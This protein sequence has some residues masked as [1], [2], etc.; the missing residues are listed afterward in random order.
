MRL[1]CVVLVACSSTTA[2]STPSP[3][4]PRS[5]DEVPM[6][7]PAEYAIDRIS[8][9]AGKAIFERTGIGDPYRTG[10]PYPIFLALL[11]AFP[12]TFGA[13]TDE[14][15]AK[16]GL[17]ARAADPKSEDRDVREGLPVGL[18]HT[19]DPITSVPFVV[20][21]CALCH[22]ESVRWTRGVG[23]AHSALVVGLGNRRVRIHAYDAAFATVTKQPGF[24]VEK[25]RRLADAAATQRK[26]KW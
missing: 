10:I 8:R 26:V 2:T 21:N 24:S 12:E 6:S 5:S 9:D 1:L 23:G 7:D 25:L 11:A 16:F 14:L 19:D 15:A 4:T 3:V 20:H 13:N 18:H 22:A 17:I